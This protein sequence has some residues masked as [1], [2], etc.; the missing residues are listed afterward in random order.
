MAES[1]VIALKFRPKTFSQVVGQEAIT[2]TLSNAINSNTL[3][4]AYLF[5]GARGV[6]KTTTARILAKSLNCINAPTTDPC[7]QC[8]ACLDIANANS[9]YVV[10]IDAATHTGIDN[11]REV[12]ITPAQFIT[13]PGHFRVFIIDEV[14]Q[15][16]SHSFNSLL[17]IVEEPPPRVIFIMAT[18]ELQKVPDTILSRCQVFEFRTIQL[19]KITAELRRIADELGIKI[20]DSALSTIAR[21]GEGSMRDA[22]SALDQVISFAGGD[23]P[24][25]A[26]SGI[27]DED[28]SA[29]LGLVSFETL[30]RTLRAVGEHDSREILAIVD[31]VVSRGFDLRNF[32]RDLMTHIRS[33]LVIKA[34]GIDT[35][36]AQMQRTEAESLTEFADLF[37]EYDLVRFFTLLSKAEQDIRLSSQPRFQLEIGL[38]KMA[39]AA[40]LQSIEEAINRL[41]AIEAS[42][43]GG[44]G[45][46]QLATPVPATR[47][48]EF[49]VRP[50][51]ALDPR[52]AYTAPAPQ[53]ERKR[54][55]QQTE[56][57]AP[58]GPGGYGARASQ[59]AADPAAKRGAQAE[60]SVAVRA[61]QEPPRFMDDEPPIDEPV[62][63]VPRQQSTSE[64]EAGLDTG[65]GESIKQALEA[66]RKMILVSALD[67]AESIQADGDYLRVTYSKDNSLFKGKLEARDSRATVEEVCREIFG[68]KVVLLVSISGAE[69]TAAPVMTTAS[70]AVPAAV[71]T[72]ASG[73][74]PAVDAAP[75]GGRAGNGASI[76]AA[77]ADRGVTTKAPTRISETTS[78]SSNEERPEDHHVVRALVE[79][80]QGE[81]IEVIKPK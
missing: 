15:L 63:P 64:G 47:G 43:T 60:D 20:S 37:S 56:R 65:I 68:K 46:S 79:K 39:Q 72:P 34:V 54:V 7:G 53:P 57:A 28:V 45:P 48:P 29:A 19:N 31:D 32:C 80:F 77:A 81:V 76:P 18:T 24:E 30:N 8:P 6:G 27:T 26:S 35:E 69:S 74:K 51:P 36:L 50:A 3:H 70:T 25:R 40:R 13:P 12:I 22:E 62:A 5:A 44:T 75:S 14:H 11:V 67:H 4:H 16:S 71:S 33:L 41:A 52:R 49:K 23:S 66:R 17:K 59:P 9:I 38:V 10:E 61:P 21:A 73:T 55:E 42:L 1:H 2:R 58:A 78:N